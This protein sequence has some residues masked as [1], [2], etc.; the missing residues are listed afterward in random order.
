[1]AE[2]SV[3]GKSVP[4]VDALEKVTGKA[5]F[6]SDFKI[7]G[8]LHAKV[9]RS[10]YPHARIIK[11][12]TSEAERLPG[13]RAVVTGKDAPDRQAG[14]LL[15]DQYFL[16]HDNI[17]RCIG[18]PVAAVAA[19]TI[20]IAEEAQDLIEVEYEELPAVFD[21]EES[22]KKD[23]PT[24]I[25]PDF[26][27][28]FAP[29]T[30]YRKT[31]NP[32]MPNV[33]LH[34]KIY[35]GDVEKGFESADLIVENR[36]STVRIVH[37]Q[38]EPHRSIAWV[39]GDGTVVVRTKT[40]QSPYL[41][42]MLANLFA[43]PPHRIRVIAPYVGGDFGA[44]SGILTEPIAILLAMK[45]GRPV[46]LVYTREEQF[47]DGRQQVSVITYIKD[48]VKRDGTLVAREI[49]TIQDCGRHSEMA[50]IV[51]RNSA[52]GAVG[53]Y[54]VPNFKL[55]NYGVYT[56]NPLTGTFRGLGSPQI[57]WAI[58][59]Q[60]DILA[61]KL[62]IDSVE[63]RKKNILK[64]GERNVCGQVTHS[65]GISEC[66]DKVAEWIEWG[67]KPVEEGGAWRRGK[68]IGIGQKYST[69]STTSVAIVKV[70]PD[71]VIE[72]R[73]NTDDIGQGVNTVLAQIAAEQFGVSMDKVK[74]VRGD[75]AFCPYDFGAISSRSTFHT[76]NA[77]VAACQDA[78]RQLFEAAAGRL[79]VSVASLETGDGKVLVKGW[80][81]RSLEI[82]DLF[83][84]ADGVPLRGGEILG[85]GSY[86]GPVVPEDE[87]GQSERIVMSFSHAAHAVEVAVNVETGEV[88]VLRIAGAFDS[89]PINPKLVE[90]QIEGGT[91]QGIGSAIYEHL[92]L[93]NG[94]VV[95]PN[96][97][98]YKLP[99]AG[100]L[101]NNK[102][103]RGIIVPT[104]HQE[105]PYE[106]KGMGEAALVPVA[107]AIANAVYNA[108]GVRI[109]DLPIS[110]EKVLEAIKEA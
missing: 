48:G 92:V 6:C 5:R 78:K 62:G 54:R 55:D 65:I 107:P 67:K 14:I 10:P 94:M 24:I 42:L 100:T 51:S 93:H 91:V 95:N 40:Q 109:K 99:T 28:Y 44:G 11:I 98:D 76:G 90:Q 71:G 13:V 110:R 87:K 4:R 88:K 68:G 22:M 102:D 61:E 58:E 17:A 66:L 73:H 49:K 2:L 37:G 84:P 25:H 104:P 43:L 101:P 69:V 9:V 59:Q 38:I 57:I 64:E 16:C 83:S 3:V 80:P 33:L 27:S 96:L 29:P 82:S 81:G 1:M 70:H 8:M 19:D 53:T 60:M 85:T 108:V 50:L 32:D 18:E 36:Y 12:D 72:V 46:S 103:I 31:V 47:V 26:P 63:I 35:N 105:G 77:V 20:E 30:F 7:G 21:P 106:A 97:T 86:F 39:E 34:F 23:P 15:L 52:F 75:T 45:S 89:L 74:V 56:N 41:Q 79:G